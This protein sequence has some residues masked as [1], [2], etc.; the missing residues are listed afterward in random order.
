MVQY[1]LLIDQSIE[2]S[3][4]TKPIRQGRH[5]LRNTGMIMDTIGSFNE[6]AV[7]SLFKQ[8]YSINQSKESSGQE[9]VRNALDSCLQQD[10]YRKNNI[11]SCIKFFLVEQKH[12]NGVNML[13]GYT[14][15][16]TV[17][18]KFQKHEGTQ[19]MLMV[20]NRY[21]CLSCEIQILSPICSEIQ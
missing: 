21:T 4:L 17:I 1:L 18:G 3:P 14:M 13:T 8:L 19:N 6:A 2:T 11:Q 5:T 12:S 10:M 20:I 16:T 9:K 7:S 15:T